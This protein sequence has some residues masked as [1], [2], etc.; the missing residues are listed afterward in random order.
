MITKF[1][2]DDDLGM[3]ESPIHPNFSEHLWKPCAGRRV[4]PSSRRSHEK[5]VTLRPATQNEL[6]LLRIDSQCVPE[7][8]IK[9]KVAA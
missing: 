4:M 1:D 6:S 2:N 9:L 5:T 3:P 7:E 8:T